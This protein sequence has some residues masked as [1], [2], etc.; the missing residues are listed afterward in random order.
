MLSQKPG[1]EIPDNFV[2]GEHVAF[3]RD[4]LSDL[5]SLLDYYLSHEDEMAEMTERAKQHLQ[6]YHTHLRRAEFL[7]DAAGFRS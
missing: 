1:I 7:I 3:C 4:D 2:H 6:K 5:T